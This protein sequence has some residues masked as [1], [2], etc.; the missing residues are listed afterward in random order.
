M[1]AGPDG[2]PPPPLHPQDRLPPSQ[3]GPLSAQGQAVIQMGLRGNWFQRVHSHQAETTRGNC[4]WIPS[5]G[6]GRPSF[7]P[8]TVMCGHLRTS[9][10]ALVSS[11]VITQ[12]PYSCS[13]TKS[14]LLVAL[15]PPPAAKQPDFCF[16]RQRLIAVYL[17]LICGRGTLW[18]SFICDHSVL[19]T[20]ELFRLPT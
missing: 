8:F 15:A 20:A 5:Y 19:G 11:Q 2:F 1:A 10:V 18:Q 4:F 6:G 3:G 13:G 16:T 12:T 7:V 17:C 9:V 14:P